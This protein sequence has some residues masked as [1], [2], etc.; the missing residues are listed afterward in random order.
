MA[1]GQ[2]AWA[3]VRAIV[4][5]DFW[6][7]MLPTKWTH[8]CSRLYWIWVK[9]LGLLR[10]QKFLSSPNVNG[11]GTGGLGLCEGNCD[12]DSDC[13]SGLYASS[14][15][16][17]PRM[18]GYKMIGIIVFMMTLFESPKLKYLVSRWIA[19]TLHLRMK[20]VIMLFPCSI[21]LEIS[22]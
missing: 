16:N 9:W 8:G 18:L 2:E 20:M 1:K 3:C 22:L 21:P 10:G 14:E 4:T 11:K 12:G 17:D 15:Q 6:P 13:A 7:E 5:P 19:R